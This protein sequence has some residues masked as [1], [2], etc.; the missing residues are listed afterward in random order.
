[1]SGLSPAQRAVLQGRAP[2][3]RSQ[4]GGF[5]KAIISLHRLG[6]L[7]VNGE[8]NE[9]GRR[10][11]RLK[12]R[13]VDWDGTGFPV[14]ETKPIGYGHL[15]LEGLQLGDE[16]EVRANLQM[17]HGRILGVF[18]IEHITPSRRFHVGGWIF[19]VG[20]SQYGAYGPGC[21]A[22]FPVSD[23]GREAENRLSEAKR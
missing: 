23:A 13:R 11:A 10:L 3:G 21:A 17:N 22:I 7:G 2:S 1:M 16:V 14:C 8:A 6:L 5:H 18:P 4:A 9:R 19:N 12:R 15:W 20:G